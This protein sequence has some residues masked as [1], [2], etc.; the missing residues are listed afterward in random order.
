MTGTLQYGYV[1]ITNNPEPM[2]ISDANGTT[3]L[4]VQ[5]ALESAA[6]ANAIKGIGSP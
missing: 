5:D 4:T 6:V 2:N 1:S 3:L